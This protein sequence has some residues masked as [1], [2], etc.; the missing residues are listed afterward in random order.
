MPST[1]LC[2]RL[3]AATSA[4]DKSY[5]RVSHLTVYLKTL[6]KDSEAVSSRVHAGCILTAAEPV[7]MAMPAMPS[8]C[9]AFQKTSCLLDIK[10]H[11]FSKVS[12]SYILLS[13]LEQ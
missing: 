13:V 5:T 8:M 12:A 2:A 4:C 6:L 9:F 1:D 7:Q 11:S 3:P 10:C